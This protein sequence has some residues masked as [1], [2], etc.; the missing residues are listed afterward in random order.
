[1]GR[2]LGTGPLL[3]GTA[4][5]LAALATPPETAPVPIAGQPSES[6]A[7]TIV[8]RA[9]SDVGRASQG[10]LGVNHHYNRN[11]YGVWDGDHDRPEPRL[12]EGAVRAGVR[13][14]R[15]PGGTIAHLYDWKRA[16]GPTRLC[17]VS[18]WRD[19]HGGFPAVTRGLQFGPDEF[20]RLT[21]DIGAEP[22]IMVPYLTETAKDAADWVEYMNAPSGP[23]NPNGGVDWGDL[24][25]ENGHPA[26][27]GVHR[28]EIGNE[29]HHGKSA[30]WMSADAR[31][32]VRQYAFGGTAEI[33]R[34]HLGKDCAHP[35]RGVLS[36]GSANQVFEALYPPLHASST[37]VTVAGTTWKRVTDL[38]A[39]GPDEKVY[40][41]R[42]LHGQ[43]VFG[44]GVHGAIPPSGHTVTA[45]YRTVHD[46]F[47]DFAKAM[48]KVDPSIRVCSAWGTPQFPAV[49]RG[50]PFD[51][52]TA[53]VITT[54]AHH[55]K[56][57]WSSPIEGHDRLMV[58]AGYRRAGIVRVKRS[59]PPGTALWLTEVAALNGDTDTW[60]E[61]TASAGYA[62]FTATL[63]GDW[64]ELHLPWVQGDDF[65]W[66]NRGVI[67]HGPEFTFT[68]L[69]VTRQALK[70]M[71]RAG[72]RVVRVSVKANPRRPVREMRTSYSALAVTATRAPD[73]TV[74]LM[75]VNRLPTRSVT[76]HVSLKGLRPDRT[77]FV[78]R[79]L[80]KSF[81]ASNRPGEPPG[82][83]LRTTKRHL[84]QSGLDQ[85]FPP[86]ST[87]VYRF[88]RR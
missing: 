76:A 22:L 5:M 42:P 81:T 31:I 14:V 16:I 72:G 80:S 58:E 24:R 47:F 59:L 36:D 51:C 29:M 53:H 70:P 3:A 86:A 71:F 69:A 68:A 54:F 56:G 34:E 13:S 4:V 79:V 78:R 17:Q 63:W 19:D 62:A 45:S 33:T 2:F 73:G 27:Y 32:A 6:R 41:V 10:L 25:A 67:G 39:S 66:A 75:V 12:V 37:S 21:H 83:W 1:M 77:V 26:P 61:W 23:G 7:T 44:D 87:T 8:V 49:A 9:R 74:W 84:R 65:V 48:K 55:G 43:V 85:H 35:V 52:L 50:R 88:T 18:G 15:F 20:M 40:E 46:G 57:D 38:S 64:M 82:V 28:W 30:H 60:P 11:G